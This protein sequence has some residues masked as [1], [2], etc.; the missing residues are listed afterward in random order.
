MSVAAGWDWAVTLM[1]GEEDGIDEDYMPSC[2][3]SIVIDGEDWGF[4]DWICPIKEYGWDQF[5]I[6][7]SNVEEN[8]LIF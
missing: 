2:N 8:L 4:V 1:Y 7:Y 6:T 5:Y 3:Y